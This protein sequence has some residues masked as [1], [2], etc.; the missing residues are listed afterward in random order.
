V[1]D[2]CVGCEHSPHEGSLRCT[3]GFRATLRTDP[4]TNNGWAD[5]IQAE[6]KGRC[7][8]R[9]EADPIHS[10]KAEEGSE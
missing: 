4:A 2:P 1:R 5:P 6:E 9:I 3:G 10:V 8:L 7:P